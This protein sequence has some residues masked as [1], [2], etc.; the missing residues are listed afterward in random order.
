[1]STDYYIDEPIPVSDLFGGRLDKYGVRDAES[2]NATDNSKC[3]T[4]GLNNY[5]WTHGNPVDCF[6]QYLPNRYPS[7]I[8]QSI[9]TE[10]GVEIYSEHE[11]VD[12]AKEGEE[13]PK[14]SYIPGDKP[15]SELT[16]EKSAKLSIGRW[17]PYG[18]KS[19]KRP[20]E[21]KR[22]KR[23]RQERRR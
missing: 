5:L 8:L 19:A 14:P 3:L 4:D 7:F 20:A 17:N 9:A 16:G 13:A 23:D 15:N 6:T 11:I 12:V 2:L 22:A 21:R 1:M 18:H 10:F